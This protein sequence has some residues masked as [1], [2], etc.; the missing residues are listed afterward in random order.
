[1]KLHE[2]QTLFTQLLNF[3]ANTLKIRP[4]FIEK[5]YWITRALQRMAQNENAEKLFSK[6]VLHY[7]KP[8]V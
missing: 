8:I 2:N 6:A 1:M 7:Q 4:E 5:D 3:S